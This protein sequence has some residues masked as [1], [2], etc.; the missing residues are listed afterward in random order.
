MGETVGRDRILEPTTPGEAAAPLTGGARA[1]GRS[2]FPDSAAKHW[3]L[4]SII[5]LTVVDLFGLVLATE[6]VTPEAFSHYSWLS[7]SRVRPSHVS[8]VILAWLTMMYFGALFYMLPRLV[9]TRGMWSE[10]LGVICAWAWNL[11]YLLGIIGLLTGHSQGR[12]YGEF[13]WPIDILLLVI[14]CANIVNILA[15]V[16]IRTIPP[17]Y[18]SVWFFIASPLWLAVDYAI[19]QSPTPAWLKTIAEVSSWM[20]LV[21]VFAFT[22]NILGTMKGNW[23]RFFTNLPLRFTMTAFFFYFLVNIQGAFEA[24]QPFNKLTHFTNFVVAHAHLALLGAFTILGMGVIDYIVAQ[25]YAKPLYSRSLSEWQYWLVT[26]GFTGFF[27]VLTLAGFQQGFSWQEGIPEVNVLP[28]L[29]AYYIARGIFR[30]VIVLSGIVQIVNIGMT[31]FTNTAERPRLET[32]RVAEAIAP[33]PVT[34]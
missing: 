21:P 33:P 1:M 14:W 8:G 25:I 2:P 31:I 3:I 7:F 6:F 20:L 32:L 24:I 22:I 4:S 12:E 15:T 28:Q 30:A 5:W 27:S 10:R 18:V 13:I 29:H 16:A 11:M 9:G 17:I 19:L 26:V 23:D 34:G